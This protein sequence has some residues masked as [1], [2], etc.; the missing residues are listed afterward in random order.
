MEV[1]WTGPAKQDLIEIYEYLFV[2]DPVAARGYLRAVRDAS[3]MI[4]HF[5]ESGARFEPWP[6]KGNFRSV[7]VRNHRLIYRVDA[8]NIVVFRVW[9]CRQDPDALWIHLEQDDG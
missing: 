9:D 2:R 5:P 6:L 8:E 3:A 7:V 4:G 1:L